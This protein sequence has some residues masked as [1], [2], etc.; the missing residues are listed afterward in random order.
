MTPVTIANKALQFIVPGGH[1][2]EPANLSAV[3]QALTFT[4]IVLEQKPG[5]P[6][7]TIAI[8]VVL[9]MVYGAALI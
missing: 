8:A 4:P 7:K 3:A 1:G 5:F 9:A 6:V 2:P